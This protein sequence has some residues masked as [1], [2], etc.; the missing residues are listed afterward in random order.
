M[1]Y[2][3]P[4][5]LHRRSEEAGDVRVSFLVSPQ[6]KLNTLRRSYL[7]KRARRLFST[8]ILIS[9]PDG[10]TIITASGDCYHRRNGCISLK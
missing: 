6:P 1:G 7:S 2:S 5:V 9:L 3:L 4:Q 8:I 10:S